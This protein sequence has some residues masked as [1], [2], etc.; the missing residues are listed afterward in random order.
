[1]I[2]KR[3]LFKVLASSDQTHIVKRNLRRS[4]LSVRLLRKLDFSKIQMM[5]FMKI[6]FILAIVP[7]DLIKATQFRGFKTIQNTRG[8]SIVTDK[9]DVAAITEC[10]L[11]CRIKPNCLAANWKD[12][13]CEILDESVGMPLLVTEEIGWTYMCKYLNIS[14]RCILLIIWHLFPEILQFFKRSV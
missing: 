9:F 6:A 2:F 14:A 7:F 3:R 10:S 13:V 4:S 12:N 11:R 8:T 5:I 1:M